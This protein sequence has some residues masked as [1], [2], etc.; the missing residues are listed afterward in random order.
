[1]W[2]VRTAVYN[3]YWSTAGGAEKYGGVIAQALSADGPLDLLAH[4]P[5]DVDWLAQR[6]NIDLSKVDVRIVEDDPGAVTAAAEDY[7]LFVNV[8]YR[9]VARAP[10]RRSLYVVHFPNP[11]EP[12][13]RGL[14]RLVARST[15]RLRSALT[16]PGVEW[17][18]GFYPPDPDVRSVAW[19]NGTGVIRLPAPR[20]RRTWLTLVL[21]H[22]RPASLGSTPVRIEVDGRT[23]AE[24][25]LR[26]PRSR[27]I[28][29]L[30]P[31]VV[32]VELPPA[33][34]DHQ[35][36]V[37]ILSDTF[38][39]AE[40][41]GGDDRRR[42]GVPVV[43]VRIGSGR[44]GRL[45][46]RVPDVLDLP[47]SSNW[48]GSY[49]AL[50]CNSEFT[51]GWVRRWWDADSEVLYPPVTMYP[52]LEK[53]PVILGVG[54]FF[55]ASYG[56][57]KK[58]LELVEAFRQLCDRGTTGW[59]LHLVGG[60]APS[61]ETYLDEVRR[62]AAGYPVEL[63]VN[64]TGEELEALYGRASIY[65]HA[66]GLGEDVDRH[67]GRSEH[68]GITTAEA[69]SA[70]AVP[71][72]IGQAGQLETVRPGVDGYHFASLEELVMLTESLVRDDERRAKM[73]A[74]AASR[75]RDFSVDAFE[76]RLRALV[77]RL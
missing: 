28:A 12:C 70:R 39:P 47:A 21:G 35:T 23:A 32:R 50:V 52:A 48:T 77:A 56:H 13:R 1:M 68:F 15:A 3:R 51:Q 63:H 53:Q 54:R 71:V 11:L 7:D 75:A 22:Q 61:G 9:S 58:Q 27:L 74:T 69:M 36:E 4:D 57:S 45:L 64:A 40:A 17:E 10:N 42:V 14:A 44:A 8:S 38:V 33:G 29:H 5:V 66:A 41:L 16:P 31:V 25:T 67:P 60:C 34:P 73:A 72:V 46:Q 59:Q 18:E 37:R 26:Q 30:R 49:G 65:W 43:A 24:V 2:S 62:A 55:D 19:T 76:Q 6:L 20:R